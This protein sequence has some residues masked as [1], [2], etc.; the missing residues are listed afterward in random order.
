M[1]EYVSRIMT[2]CQHFLVKSAWSRVL[3][4]IYQRMF[5]NCSEV[6]V[7][8]SRHYASI[9]TFLSQPVCQTETKRRSSLRYAIMR[10]L[11]SSLAQLFI[12][13]HDHYLILQLLPRTWALI[14]PNCPL[15]GQFESLKNLKRRQ[16]SRNCLLNRLY[17]GIEK[18]K[19]WIYSIIG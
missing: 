11:I 14:H 16:R 4:S 15:P 3:L 5:L 19:R 10:Q 2:E 13:T 9:A 6:G 12:P 7:L 1:D 8:I 17:S 18:D